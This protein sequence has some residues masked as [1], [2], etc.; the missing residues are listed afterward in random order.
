[1]PVLWAHLAF[2]DRRAESLI[3]DEFTQIR[4]QR[5]L[6][7]SSSLPQYLHV[8]CGNVP[9]VNS[10]GTHEVSIPVLHEHFT[11]AAGCTRITCS[12]LPVTKI[13]GGGFRFHCRV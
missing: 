3:V 1:M 12:T 4:R 11:H 2:L 9:H 10:L 8:R 5:N 7:R 13:A 6:P